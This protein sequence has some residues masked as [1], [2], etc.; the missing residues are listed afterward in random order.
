MRPASEATACTIIVVRTS[1]QLNCRPWLLTRV[2]WRTS[3]RR[4]ELVLTMRGSTFCA[5]SMSRTACT[6]S[7]MGTLLGWNLTCA[8]SSALASPVSG[9]GLPRA[10]PAR[11][12]LAAFTAASRTVSLDASTVVA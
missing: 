4:M 10:L 3:S 8:F 5:R 2:F 11:A 7:S 9:I 1:S 12:F 6:F